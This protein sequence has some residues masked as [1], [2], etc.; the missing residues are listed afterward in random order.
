MGAWQTPVPSGA[1]GLI[2]WTL[3]AD[4]L[5]ARRDPLPSGRHRVP[6][7]R[8]A[9]GGPEAEM[10]QD[11][12]DNLTQLNER[13]EPQWASAPR[14]HERVHLVRVLDEARALR[15]RGGDLVDFLNGRWRLS[16]G[17]PP[18]PPIQVAVPPEEL[19]DEGLVNPP[20]PQEHPEYPV[21]EEVR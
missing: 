20:F 16:L 15:G 18:L 11:L 21:A 14:A 19:S 1:D 13:D 4:F 2:S 7:D 8:R 5:I 12:F 10:R 9:V 17:L 3:W 6:R